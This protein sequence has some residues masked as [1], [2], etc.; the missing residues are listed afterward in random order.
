M[1]LDVHVSARLAAKLY[2]ERDE[3]ILK[4]LPDTAPEDF[5]SLTMPVREEAWRWP[6]DLFPFFR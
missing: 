3:Y 2:R 6:R 4:Y 1:M 5:V